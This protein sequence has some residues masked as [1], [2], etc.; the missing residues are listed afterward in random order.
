MQSTS[1]HQRRTSGFPKVSAIQTAFVITPQRRNA[2]LRV[3]AT[4]GNEAPG[5]LNPPVAQL[6]ALPWQR[7]SVTKETAGGT[8]VG[9]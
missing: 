7:L 2:H 1:N 3:L 9:Q 5:R 8:V 4:F 6:G